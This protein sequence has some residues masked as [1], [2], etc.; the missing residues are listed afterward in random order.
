MALVFKV[1]TLNPNTWP[2]P[3]SHSP[4]GD[5]AIEL[6]KPCMKWARLVDSI[7]KELVGFGICIFVSDVTT[8][9]D[10]GFCRPYLSCPGPRLNGP[11]FCFKL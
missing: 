3:A 7:Q 1:N 11:N 2:S 10:L 4:P 6:L 9:G 8:R 5:W